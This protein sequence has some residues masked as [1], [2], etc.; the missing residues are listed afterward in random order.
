MESFLQGVPMNTADISVLSDELAVSLNPLRRSAHRAR[1]VCAKLAGL[2]MP[3][4]TSS[5]DAEPRHRVRPGSMPAR[6]PFPPAPVDEGAAGQAAVLP[7]SA[8]TVRPAAPI[9]PVP[10]QRHGRTRDVP[11]HHEGHGD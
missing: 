8:P 4:T 9:A 11:S 6:W 1:A 2:A 5:A 10:G 3:W 7:V